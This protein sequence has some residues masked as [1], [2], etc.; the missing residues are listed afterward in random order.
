MRLQILKNGHSKIQ[1][2]FLT[3]IDKMMGGFVPG[4][5]M[6]QSYRADFFGKPFNKCVEMAL[7]D[8]KTWRKSEVELLAAFVSKNNACQFCMEA[9]SAVAG[10]GTEASVIQAVLQDWKTAPVDN[11]MKATLGFL[12]KMTRTPSDVTSEDLIPMLTAG[13]TRQG[14]EEALRICFVFCTIN[15]LADAFGFELAQG[16]QRKRMGFMLFNF[17]YGIAALP[18]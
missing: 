11:K 9:H 2:F 1:K 10:E 13:V 16:Q 12:E 8:T 3:I 14:I 6:M 15:R 5:I 17:G 4:P 7:R 18:G